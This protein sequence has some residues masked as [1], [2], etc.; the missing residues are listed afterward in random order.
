MNNKLKCALCYLGGVITGGAAV[1]YFVKKYYEEKSE[2]EIDNVR[3]FYIENYKTESGSHESAAVMN[4][5]FD[6]EERVTQSIKN[7][8]NKMTHT[9]YWALQSK[10]DA[11]TVG[12]AVQKPVVSVITANEFGSDPNYAIEYLT[13]YPGTGTLIED[14]TQSHIDI[15]EYFGE[16]VVQAI[17]GWLEYDHGDDYIQDEV[18]IKDDSLMI[19]YA[20]RISDDLAPSDDD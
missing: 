14:S 1:F 5:N 7:V 2:M 11:R 3:R 15:Y 13:Y 9:D 6:A 16:D 4:A 20:V 17:E 10:A 19:Y 12:E 8:E 18:S